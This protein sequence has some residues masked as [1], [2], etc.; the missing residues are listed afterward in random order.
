MSVKQK[1]HKNAGRCRRKEN[2]C[3]RGAYRPDSKK[4]APGSLFAIVRGSG[5]LRNRVYSGSPQALRTCVRR[6]AKLS[7]TSR[8]L[9]TQVRSALA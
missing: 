3:T 8:L 1:M 5:A 7:E 2:A 4:A 9:V 6:P